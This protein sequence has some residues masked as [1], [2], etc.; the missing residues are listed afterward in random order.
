MPLQAQRLR[1]FHA[2]RY[3]QC[4]FVADGVGGAPGVLLAGAGFFALRLLLE[5]RKLGLR[6]FLEASNGTPAGDDMAKGPK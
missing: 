3:L 2:R 4:S 1:P 5:G 6:L